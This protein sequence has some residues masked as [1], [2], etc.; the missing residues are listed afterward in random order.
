MGFDRVEDLLYKAHA[1]G[2]YNAVMEVSKTLKG[3]YYTYADKLE[4]AYNIV[5][6]E[7]NKNANINKRTKQRN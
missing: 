4:E 6:K 7:K 3:S 5:I 2:L 1:E